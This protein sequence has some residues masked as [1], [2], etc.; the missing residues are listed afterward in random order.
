M[1]PQPRGPQ[2]PHASPVAGDDAAGWHRLH[3]LSPLVRGGRHLVGIGVLVVVLLFANQQHAGSDLISDLFV[4]AMVLVAGVV[5]WLVTRWQVINGVL[6]IETGLIRRQ[7][8][9]FPLSQVQAIDVVQTGLARV[10]GLAEIR[11]RMA[12]A[13]SSGGRLACLPLAEAGQLRRSLLSMT[14]APGAVGVDAPAAP[15]AAATR[16]GGEGLPGPPAAAGETERIL[17]RVR[18]GRLA[19]ALALSRTGAIAAIMI[20]ALASAAALSGLPGIGAS[21][22]PAGLGV[23]L[24]V[25][26]QFNG[27]F[28]TVV[29]AAPDGLRLRSGL[30]QTTAETIRPGR[31][32]AVRLVEPLVWRAFGWCRLEVDVA[33]PRQRRENRSESRHLRAL[34]PVGSRAEAEQMLGELMSAPPVPSRRPPGGARW[35]APLAYHF[36]A[37][38]GDDRYVAASHGRVCRKTT[39]VPLE[40]V[41]SIRWVQGPVQRQLGLASVRLDVA[42]RRVTASLQDRGAA[43]ALDLLS[44]LPDLARAA[45]TRAV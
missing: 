7:S 6:Y 29:A 45:R 16:P 34:I 14:R 40:K 19:G 42:G 21:L 9:R 39:W 43:E 30:V 44:R 18:S 5:N 26:R 33:G 1:S 41:Q 35:K 10:L 8:Q 37:W 22:L 3:P 2:R 4:V 23:V 25:W 28:G 11:V 20:A 17:F 13:D 38:G 27:E 15:S 24:A 31:V 36:L 32:Q 12:G